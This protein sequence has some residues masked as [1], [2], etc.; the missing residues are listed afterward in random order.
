M[1]VGGGLRFTNPGLGLTFEVKARGLLTHEEKD[2]ADW[3][4]GGMLR[5]APG[6]SGKG[7][8]L[9]VRPEVG[10]TARDADRLWGLENASR[11]AKEE[12]GS[13]DPRVRAEVGYGLDAWGGLLTPYA[14]LSVSEGGN[15]AYRLGGRFKVGERLSMSLEG[16]VRERE[17]DGPVH[18]VALRG[19]LRW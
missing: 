8:A 7:L 4:V 9:T 13:L 5:I 2:M 3:G 1:E 19:S 6:G 17:D 14:G 15:G 11:L 10:E 18:G 16:D 12:I